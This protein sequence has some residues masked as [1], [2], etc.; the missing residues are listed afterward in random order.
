[1]SKKRYPVIDEGMCIQCGMCEAR[2]PNGV[3][4]ENTAPTPIVVKPEN[5]DE[6]CGECAELCPVRAISYQN[7]SEGNE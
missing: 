4:D 3:Y 6:N 1:M 5:C 7:I 2:C